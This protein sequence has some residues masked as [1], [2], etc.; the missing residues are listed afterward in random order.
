VTV[1]A[2]RGINQLTPYRE[3]YLAAGGGG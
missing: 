1:I 2:Y 3:V